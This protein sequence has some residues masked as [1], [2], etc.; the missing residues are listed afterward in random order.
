MFASRIYSPQT[1][2]NNDFL[3]ECIHHWPISTFY[4]HLLQN[5]NFLCRWDQYHHQYKYI[6]V[7][8]NKRKL[9]TGIFIFNFLIDKNCEQKKNS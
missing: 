8:K 4:Y 6:D 5:I 9:F 1:G 2:L 7:P 3:N